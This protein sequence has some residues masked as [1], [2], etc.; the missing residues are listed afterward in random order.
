MKVLFHSSN[1]G[2]QQPLGVLCKWPLGQGLETKLLIVPP[3]P[4]P[5]RIYERGGQ[6]VLRALSN[7]FET[8]VLKM[9]LLQC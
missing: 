5:G 9:E 3:C 7:A 8:E 2:L 4:S 1:A 6:P